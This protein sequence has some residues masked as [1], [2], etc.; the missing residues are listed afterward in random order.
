MDLTFSAFDHRQ[1][2][3]EQRALFRDAFPE[4]VGT[5]AETERHYLWKFQ[6]ALPSHE[7]VA[8]LPDGTMDGY[9]A[10]IEFPYR[11]RESSWTGAMVCDGMTSSRSRGKGVF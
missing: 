1:E 9:Y 5:A 4:A 6:V 3:A 2:L 8:R 7:Y 10:E 11:G